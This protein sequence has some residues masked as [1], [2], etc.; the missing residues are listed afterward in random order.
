MLIL[1]PVAWPL[2][3]ILDKAWRSPCPMPA[4]VFC[5]LFKALGTQP[6][7]AAMTRV[8]NPAPPLVPMVQILGREVGNIY[9]RAELKHLIQIHVENPEHQEESGL[10]H[11]DHQLLSGALDYKVP[12]LLP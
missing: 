8:L 3:F 9:S 12:R 7:L 1:S 10:T 5:N 11:E 6:L 4:V 2:A